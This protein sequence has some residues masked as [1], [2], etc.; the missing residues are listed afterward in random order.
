MAYTRCHYF[1]F[2][3]SI[4]GI[5]RYKQRTTWSGRGDLARKQN[6]CRLLRIKWSTRVLRFWTI[7]WGTDRNR[8]NAE[9]DR[10][11]LLPGQSIDL[12]LWVTMFLENYSKWEYGDQSLGNGRRIEWNVDHTFGRADRRCSDPA[13]LLVSGC[14]QFKGGQ[15]VK[16]DSSTSRSLPR[17]PCDSNAQK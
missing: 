3:Y 9:P 5:F 14:L 12:H 11:D 10:H 1:T 16:V 8:R 4:D 15:T 17:M 2:R 6:I 7:R 13:G